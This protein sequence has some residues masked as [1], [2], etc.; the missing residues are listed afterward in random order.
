MTRL[1]V[2]SLLL[3]VFVGTGCGGQS[4]PP[5][6]TGVQTYEVSGVIARLPEGPG[7]ELMISHEEI[8]DFV[9]AAGDTVGMKAMTMGFPV[10]DQI[11]LTEFAAGDSV[12]IRFEVRWGQPGPLQLTRMERR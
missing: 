4:E 10:S 5:P 12:L 8:P 11:D 3:F 7:T 2:L 9:N 6:R 1:V